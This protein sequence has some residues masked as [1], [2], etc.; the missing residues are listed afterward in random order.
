[1]EREVTI[2]LAVGVLGEILNQ[3]RDGVEVLADTVEYLEG[4]GV[5]TPCVVANCTDEDEARRMAGFYN[6]AISR[7][8]EALAF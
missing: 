4:G 5:V 6:D 8:E 3:L 2:S 1:M 7:I